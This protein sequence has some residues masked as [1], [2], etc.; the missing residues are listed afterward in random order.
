MEIEKKRQLQARK[1]KLGETEPKAASLVARLERGGMALTNLELI[2]RSTRDGSPRRSWLAWWQPGEELQQRFDFAPEVLMLITPWDEA[3]AKDVEATEQALRRGL[4]AD[5]GLVL[6]LAQDREAAQRLRAAFEET[7]RIYVVLDFDE[8]AR[9]TDAIGWLSRVLTERLGARDLFAS[10]P[11]V[12]GWDFFGRERELGELRAH[13]LAGRPVCIHGLGKV[14]KSSLLHRL[15]AQ[16]IEEGRDAR[17]GPQVTPVHVDLQTVIFEKTRVG[18]MR[19]LLI[20]MVDTLRA[21][22]ISLSAAGLNR[23]RSAWEVVADLPPE[24]AAKEASD[25]LHALIRFA[26]AEG[27]TVVV[28]LDEYERLYGADRGIPPAEGLAVLDLLRGLNQQY[29]RSFCFALV[30]RNREYAQRARIDGEVNPLYNFAVPFPVAGLT[31]E[32]L[33]LLIHRIGKRAGVVFDER[34][35]D[36]VEQESGGHPFLARQFCRVVERP[37]PPS[38][39]LPRELS[40]EEVLRPLLEFRREVRWTMEEILHAVKRLDPRAPT[41]LSAVGGGMLHE[42]GAEVTV[43]AAVLDE[44]VGV[45]VLARADGAL[46][47]R[48]GAF[49]AW[50]VENWAPTEVHRAAG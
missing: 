44:L 46:R 38:E 15:R 28:T 4:R 48:I 43:P 31:R 45:G 42:N 30:G 17:G 29:P 16:W 32:D 26:R 37:I 47:V 7:R 1:R 6:V 39:R 25:A 2:D 8:L 21:M 10:G 19:R 13:L 41:F 24:Q 9:A 22:G 12:S 35:I 20:A 23:D 11:P 5:R 3:Q 18:V 36:L 34:A 27:G 14:G 49:R 33:G 50:M 40:R